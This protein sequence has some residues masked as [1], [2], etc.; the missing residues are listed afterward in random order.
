MATIPWLA[1]VLRA[2]GVQVVEHGDWRNYMRPGSFDP[3]GVLW[4]H[5]AASTSSP[6]NPHPGLSVVINGRPDLP[7]PLAQALVDYNG[8]FHVISAG[9]CNHAGRSGGSGPI[10]VGD[11]NTMMVGWEIDYNGVSQEMSPAQYWASVKATAAVLRRLGRGAEFARGH[12]ETSTTGKID[13]AFIDLNAMRADVAA[14]LAGSGGVSG[15]AY[16]YGDSQHFTAVNTGGTLTNFSWSPS[17]GV[18]RPDWGGAALAG[19]T[20]G[21]VHE[22]LQHVFAR[23]ADDTLRHWFQSGGNP[24]GLDDWDTA[25]LVKSAPAGFPYGS[26]QHVFFRNPQGRL[27]HRFYDTSGHHLN[28][29]VWGDIPFVGNP[30]AFVHRD[31]QHVFARTASGGLAHWYWWPGI[32][33]GHDDWGVTSGVASDP[34]GFSYRGQQH[35]VFFRNTAGNLE[36]RFFDD[37]SGTVNGGVW[38]GGGFEGNPHAFVHRDQQHVFARRPGGDLAHWYWWPGIDAGHDDWGVR[39]VVAG[40]PAGLSVPGQHH[41]FFRTGDGSLA[42]R[43]FI[44]DT[45]HIGADNWGGGIAA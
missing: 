34:T 20:V 5:T 17:T 25:G 10:P 32:D 41:V 44:D 15:T 39:G 13:P 21:Y 3:I 24:P 19:R 31:Q 43:F 42:H 1:D 16:G 12:K 36:H 40:D 18:I 8:V 38:P 2:E 27:E 9:R 37:P 7:G 30:V 4:H 23:G 26:Q 35:H 11:G 29:G 6:Q 28:G 33:P 14:H 22:G 45:G